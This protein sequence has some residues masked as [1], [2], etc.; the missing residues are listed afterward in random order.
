MITRP[1]FRYS[2]AVET[3]GEKYVFLLNEH[4]Y[5]ALEGRTYQR[6]APL[7][8]GQHTV[9]EIVAQLDGQVPLSEI[10]YAL[11]S[12]EKKGHIVEADDSLPL[13]SAGGGL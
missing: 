6:I 1:R 9:D 8:D 3:A 2:W 7:L 4:R 11:Q 10:L 13:P 5:V 12:L